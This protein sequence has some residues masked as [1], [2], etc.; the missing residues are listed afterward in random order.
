MRKGLGGRRPGNEATY[1][2]RSATHRFSQVPLTKQTLTPCTLNFLI[3]TGM[4]I[5]SLSFLV[6]SGDEGR[7]EAITGATSVTLAT[8]SSAT[9]IA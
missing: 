7:G 4:G 5:N 1:S 8:D 3:K 9:A 6:T 2:R